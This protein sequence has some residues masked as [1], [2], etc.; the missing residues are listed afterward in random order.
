M[1]YVKS[2]Q[3]RVT[4]FVR[5][6]GGTLPKI[7]VWIYA[8]VFIACGLLTIFGVVYEFVSHGS[9]NYKAVNDCIREYFAPSVA[10]TMG[11]IGV[12]LID[13]DM[14][15]VPDRWEDKKEDKKDEVR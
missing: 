10:G 4:K 1:K 2:L 12:L 7:F 15:G 9:V 14:D 8:S 13:K 11:V 5:K 6:R 3:Q